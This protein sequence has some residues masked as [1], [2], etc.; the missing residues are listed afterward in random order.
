MTKTADSYRKA[1]RYEPWHYKVSSKER[2]SLWS[3][4]NFYKNLFYNL[5]IGWA[6]INNL[7]WNPGLAGK[8]STDL[9]KA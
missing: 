6:E 9:I 8:I 1:E 2:S 7:E 3:Y 4:E 5:F